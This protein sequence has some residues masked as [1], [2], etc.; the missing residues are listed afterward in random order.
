MSEASGRGPEG[1]APDQ[2][3]A[4]SAGTAE[5]ALA[6][7]DQGSPGTGGQQLLHGCPVTEVSGQRSVHIDA[8]GYLALME[9][10]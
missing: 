6:G 1:G 7:E 9:A 4:G 8:K 2:A 5:E 3:A 10:L